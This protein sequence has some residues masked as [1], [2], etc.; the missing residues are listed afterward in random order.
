LTIIATFRSDF[1]PSR[2]AQTSYHTAQVPLVD[3]NHTAANP[4]VKR[5]KKIAPTMAE[6]QAPQQVAL[7]AL[8]NQIG[9]AIVNGTNG[10]LVKECSGEM[11]TQDAQLLYQMVLESGTILKK[12]TCGTNEGSAPSTYVDALTKNR[13]QR[14]AEGLKRLTVTFSSVTYSAA[15]GGDGNLYIIKTKTC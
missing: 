13:R 11:T 4:F 10:S 15:L 3:R 9:T 12:P 8:P 7:E 14:G 2:S 6:V 1:V 5:A